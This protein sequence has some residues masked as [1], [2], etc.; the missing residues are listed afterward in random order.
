MST[1]KLECNNCSYVNDVDSL[2][3]RQRKSAGLMYTCKGEGCNADLTQSGQPAH[4]ARGTDSQK[5]SRKQEK[6]MAK[7]LGGHVQPASGAGQAKGDVRA[8]W[9]ARG[10]CKL[11][12]AKS[13]SLKLADLEKIER[14]A[15]STETPLLEIEFQGVYPHKRYVVLP[16]WVFDSLMED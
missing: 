6:R 15:A 1:F 9:K 14:E 2:V 12:R 7:R 13:F 16:G 8:D 4:R 10:E 3:F 11:T 5:R